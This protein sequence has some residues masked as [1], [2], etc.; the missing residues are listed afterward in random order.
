MRRYALSLSWIPQGEGVVLD[1]AS[2]AGHFGE[3]LC[4]QRGYRLETPGFFNLEKDV[5]LIPMRPS[6]GSS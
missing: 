3:V 2:G 5:A 1:P 4:D 6:T